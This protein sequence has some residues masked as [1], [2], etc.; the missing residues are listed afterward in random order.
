MCRRTARHP[1]FR[2]LLCGCAWLAFTWT[3]VGAPFSLQVGD[4]LLANYG[5]NNVLKVDAT[6]G[7]Q[8]N[9]G[10]FDTPTDLALASDGN[11]YVSEWGG[12]IQR[13]NLT[14]GTLSRLNPGTSLTQ[15]WGLTL[16]ANGELFVTSA[17]NHSV[18]RIDPVS[19]AESVV[20]QNNRLSS[21]IGIA[22]LDAQ[23]VVVASLFNNEL[24]SVNV[25][26]GTQTLLAGATNG[27]DQP[28]GVAVR[29]SEIFVTA[30]DQKRVLRVVGDTVTLFS[31]TPGFPYGIAAR[32]AGAVVVGSSAATDAVLQLNPAGTLTNSFAGGLIRQVTGIDI[33]A[34][35]LSADGLTNSPPVIDPLPD[36][37]VTVGTELRFVA[38]AVDADWPPQRLTF[39]L[40][41]GAPAGAGISASGTFAWTPTNVLA[42]AVITIRVADDGVPS[43]SATQ[44]FTVSVTENTAPVVTPIPA[45]TVFGGSPLTLTVTGTDRDTPVEHLVFSL[46]PDAPPGASL[47]AN[48]FFSWTPP[49][50]PDPAAYQ[51]AV[52]ATDDGTPPIAGSAM[53]RIVVSPPAAVE[54]GDILVA[55]SGSDSV[56]KINPSTGA[57]QQL[58]GLDGPADLALSPEGVW[59]YVLEYGGFVRRLNLTNGIS[60]V[61]NP[62]TPNAEAWALVMAPDGLLYVADTAS[63]TIVRLDP[64]TGEETDLSSSSLIAQPIGIDVLDPGHLVVSSLLNNALVAVALADGSQTP[65]LQDAGLDQTW[66]VAVSGSSIFL[67]SLGLETVQ[68]VSDQVVTDLFSASGTPFGV[69]LDAAGNLLVGVSGTNETVVRLDSQGNVLDTYADGLISGATGIEVYRTPTLPE[70]PPTLWSAVSVDSTYTHETEAVVD[71]VHRT[72]RA[73]LRSPACFYRLQ[74][75]VAVRVTQVQVQDSH[76]QLRYEAP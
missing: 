9:L 57:Q 12:A 11:L 34:V 23:H 2:R 69:A 4:L 1:R 59:L 35:N 6:T 48:G 68:V 8:Q 49:I 40:D 7:A 67:T 37:T 73:P 22:A 47:S 30:Y 41:P 61:L 51:M 46:G 3:A 74:S 63:D 62:D 29:N 52:I 44:A 14:N 33:A 21:P 36:R 17:A 10:T 54:P 58:A 32:P 42:P 27:I 71:V 45:Q 53:L 20:T 19:G 75:T 50:G 24:V 70:T 72:I 28:W 15:V 55:C 56:I 18:V 64:S 26:D 25:G 38:T 66:A 60:T 65:I 31:S 43:L 76:V 16:G 39:T 13:L 5:G